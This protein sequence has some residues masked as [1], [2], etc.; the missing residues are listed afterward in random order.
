MDVARLTRRLRSKLLSYI[1][2]SRER[3]G[4]SPITSHSSRLIIST[5]VALL[6]VKF[7]V[8]PVKLNKGNTSPQ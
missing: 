1:D 3:T 8:T 4:T 5:V 2:D 7:M 6:F